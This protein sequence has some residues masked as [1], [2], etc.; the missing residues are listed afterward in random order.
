MEP[1]SLKGKK[2]VITGASSGIGRAT[3][4]YCSELGAKIVLIAR[5]KGR[6]E[7]TLLNMKNSG[8][9]ILEQDLNRISEFDDLFEKLISDDIKADGLI[10]CVGIPCVVPL[11]SLSRKKLHEVME[12]NFYSFVGLVRSFVKRKYSN[13][14]A[15]IVGISAATVRSPRMYEMG[16]VASKAALEAVVPI[17]AMECKKREIRVNCIEP[18]NVYTEMVDKIIEEN[19]NKENLDK[20]ASEAI[21]GWQKP[22]DIAKVC[23]FL[24][25]D[26]SAT[27]TASVIRADGGFK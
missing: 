11:K 27:I 7:E 9:M 17:M 3:A 22:E 23:A 25:S 1:M 26:I 13:K 6:L 21:L 2:I 19:D 24:L 4:I 8:H 15:S 12:T 18:G 5:N 16:Y 10:H 14:G 20:F